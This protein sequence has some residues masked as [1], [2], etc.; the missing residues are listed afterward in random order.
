MKLLRLIQVLTGLTISVTWLS[1]CSDWQ[2]TPVTVDE[3]HGFAVRKMIADQTLYPE[4][5]QTIT[6]VRVMDGAKGQQIIRA[7]RAP[8]TDLRQG[9]EGVDFNAE[10]G[11]D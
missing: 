3:H 10:I 11:L 9:K 7:Y 8:A 2:T 6:E 1:G 5:S 4:H